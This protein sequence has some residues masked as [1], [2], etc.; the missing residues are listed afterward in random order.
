M[1]TQNAINL[2]ATGMTAYDGNGTFFGR[3][4]TAGN[5]GITITNGNGVS[6]N[7]TIS[8]TGGGGVAWTDVTGATQTLATN[9]GYVT[10]HSTTV[11]YTLPASANLG[12]AIYIVGKLGLATVAQNANQQILLSS[13][14]STVGAGGSITATNVGDCI[15]LICIT[16]GASTVWRANDVVGNWT[17]V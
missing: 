12:D 10:D 5:A 9:N 11:T 2:N 14:S 15:T 16:S 3:T 4:I 7:P 17:I 1:A 13:S 8:V 6:G